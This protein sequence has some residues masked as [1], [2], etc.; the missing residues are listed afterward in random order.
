M[1]AF[2]L[3]ISLLYNWAFKVKLTK[4]IIDWCDL[5][6]AQD[7]TRNKLFLTKRQNTD[8]R[9]DQGDERRV[10]HTEGRTSGENQTLCSNAYMWNLE[11]WH[12]WSQ[13]QGMNRDTDVENILVDTAGKGEGGMNLEGSTDI[14]TRPWVKQTAS[15]ELLY[16]SGTSAR[17]S[18][19]T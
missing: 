8:A 11:R 9:T 4:Q 7:Y 17:G 6:M 14:Y 3:L 12:R 15:G 18:V 1:P 5:P 10:C 2:E 16:N 13:W 19:M